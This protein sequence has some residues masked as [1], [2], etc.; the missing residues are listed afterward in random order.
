MGKR[1]VAKIVAQTSKLDAV[2]V[3]VRDAESWLMFLEMFNH[4]PSQVSNTYGNY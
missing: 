2:D 3:P 4:A 1:A